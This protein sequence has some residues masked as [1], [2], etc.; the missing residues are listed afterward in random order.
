MQH[1]ASKM[2]CNRV[3][4]GTVAAALCRFTPLLVGLLGFVGFSALTPPLAMSCC[5]QR[6]CYLLW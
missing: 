4:L 3:V 1:H 6:H 2:T 5:R